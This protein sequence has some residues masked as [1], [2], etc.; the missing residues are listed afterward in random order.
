VKG[1]LRVTGDLDGYAASESRNYLVGP[2]VEV[3][4]PLRLSVEVDAL[5][6]RFGLRTTNGDFGSSYTQ[7]QRAN[8]WEF[9][10]LAKFRPLRPVF[11]EGGFVPRTMSG[12][13]HYESISIDFF[14]GNSKRDSGDLKTSYDASRGW[15]VG[16]GVELPLRRL[17]VAPEVR[18][19][20]WN[21][22]PVDLYGSHGYFVQST[23]NRA[24][25]IIGLWWR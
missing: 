1:G 3:K 17:R 7:S 10:I 21:D 11:V 5:Y 4:L 12:S 15:I 22:R 18:Y 19:T 16:G 25:I 14:S 2:A 20:R 8:S 9:P 6:S 23:Q 13:T 24:D